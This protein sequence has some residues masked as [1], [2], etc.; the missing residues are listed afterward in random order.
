MKWICYTK[1]YAKDQCIFVEIV[2]LARIG[3]VAVRKILRLCKQNKK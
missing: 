3:C 1:N 2:I